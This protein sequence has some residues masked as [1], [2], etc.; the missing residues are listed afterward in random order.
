MGAT[1]AAC[2][3]TLN[4][5]ECLRVTIPYIKQ[6]ADQVVVVDAGSIDGSLE[7]L[8][9]FLGPNDKIIELPEREILKTGLD[10]PRNR[11][12]YEATTDWIFSLEADCFLKPSHAAQLRA[13]LGSRSHVLRVNRLNVP[14]CSFKLAQAEQAIENSQ[15]DSEPKDWIYPRDKGYVYR[16][17]VHEELYLGEERAPGHPVDIDVY[18]LS[19][20]RQQRNLHALAA[21]TAYRMKMVVI[22]PSLR[23]GVN[24][25][26]WGEYYQSNRAYLDQIADAFARDNGLDYSLPS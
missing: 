2:I 10:V 4:D 3:P 24:P 19:R 8:R 13:L 18:H 23:V 25:Y 5:V 1:I 12:A 11:A 26:W 15:C 16:G 20:I 17:Y 9:W 22:H 6:W 21:K 14:S 7:F